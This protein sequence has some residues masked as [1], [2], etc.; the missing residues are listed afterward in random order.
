MDIIL[1]PAVAGDA[2]AVAAIHA[3]SWRATYRGT[4]RDAYLDGDLT[5]ERLALWRARLAVPDGGAV[6]TI[7]EAARAPAGAGD[8]DL[9]AADHGAVDAAGDAAAHAAG[10]SSGE[11]SGAV[12]GFAW[13]VLR[14]DPEWGM[15][16][17]NLH[18]RPDLK[19]RGIGRRL[20]EAVCRQAAALEPA[21]G[22]YLWVSEANT[23]ART[24]YERLGGSVEERVVADAPGGGR[25]AEVRYAWPTVGALLDAL[26]EAAASGV[27]SRPS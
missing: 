7:A 15:L 23:D 4:L 10:E 27:L 25:V 9:D 12:V 18:V 14:A 20:L 19:A 22:V 26:R 21:A 1:R 13:I 6:G 5:A 11:S 16:L 17:D 8:G 2:P 24:F 3:Q